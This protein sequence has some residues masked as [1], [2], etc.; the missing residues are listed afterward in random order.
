[1]LAT[2]GTLAVLAVL[3]LDMPAATAER[4]CPDGEGGCGSA[5]AS[6]RLR[7]LAAVGDG[8]LAGAG[9]G[10]LVG[11]GA[12]GQV[13]SPA[14]LV[15]R[16]AHVALP[17]P[18]VDLPGLPPPLVIVDANRNGRLDPGEIRLAAYGRVGL[19]HSPAEVASNLAVPGEDVT[20]VLEALDA[21]ALA[22][23]L[24]AGQDVA[25]RDVLKLLLLGPPFDSGKLSQV[26]RVQEL[27]PTLLLL[28][29]GNENALDLVR[30]PGTA[31]AALTPAEFGRRMRRVLDALAASGSGMAVANL[32]DP[33][34]LPFLRHAGSDVSS[35]RTANGATVPADIDT[36]L[37]LG[38]DP[39]LLP[40]PPCDVA[41]T[42]ERRAMVRATVLAFNAEIDAA[43]ADLDRRGTPVAS[44]DLFGLFDRLAATGLDLDGDGSPDATTRYL[45]GIFGL[46]GVHP[47]R[48][49]NALIAN[50]IIQATNARFGMSIPLVDVARVAARDP[51]VRN[52]YR[53]DGEPPFGLFAERGTT[54]AVRVQRRAVRAARKMLRQLRRL[55]R[56][57]GNGSQRET[58]SGR[59]K[60]GTIGALP[61]LEPNV[62]GP[63]DYFM[64]SG[65]ETGDVREADVN[66]SC[67]VVTSPV[68]TGTRA[69]QLTTTAFPPSLDARPLNGTEAFVRAY[70]RVDVTALPSPTEACAPILGIDVAG[71]MPLCSADVCVQPDGQVQYRLRDR[72]NAA[73]IGTPTGS[74]PA[75]T[76]R[77]VEV[78]VRV[79]PGTNN[80]ECEF[81]LDGALVAAATALNL[82][83][84]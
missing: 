82:G 10:G 74:L 25:T 36:L 75:A 26:Q 57:A 11:Q 81:R 71:G 66:A 39:R 2:A 3:R 48:T 78:R 47:G 4:S 51:L 5:A 7:R 49:G 80:D 15:A 33:T 29:I 59:R 35:C 24:E 64:F 42:P 16:Q 69:C 73:T 37:P 65:L 53:P 32:P 77:R 54:A 27:S 23:R 68:C 72:I 56:K 70:H 21:Q 20:T 18:L 67:Q 43:V 8:F 9:S 38:L 30:R 13:D 31:G 50:A 12:P 61:P 55:R 14:A 58:G 60:P 45:G 40:I 44:V 34:L 62:V 41:V 6:S 22:G 28:W 79:L 19:R 46:D 83:D 17:Q 52:R 84:G 1:M 63:P 76:W